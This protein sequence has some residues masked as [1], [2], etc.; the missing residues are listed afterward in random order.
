MI[1]ITV[2]SSLLLSSQLRVYV[3]E[4]CQKNNKTPDTQFGFYPV[5]NT[6]QPVF[7]LRHLLH[8]AQT[9]KP[10]G[11]PRLHAAFI[12]FKQAYDSIS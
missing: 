3:T 8:A 7:I 12:D 6:L 11:L 9:K 2:M 4:W 10:H 5:R 1:I